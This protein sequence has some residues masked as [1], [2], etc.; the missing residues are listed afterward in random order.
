M[1]RKKGIFDKPENIKNLIRCFYAILILLILLD[2]F[3]HK[4]GEF[5]WENAIGFFAAYGFVS[6]V[7]VITIAKIL[8]FL[9]KKDEDYYD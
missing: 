8:R 9:L 7:F 6:C 1:G 3:I 4:H 2:P 5:Y